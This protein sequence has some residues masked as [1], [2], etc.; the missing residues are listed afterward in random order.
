[1]RTHGFPLAPLQPISGQAVVNWVFLIGD[2]FVLRVNRPNVETDD[3]Y[4]ERVAVPAAR[5]A[6]I[7]TPELL[8]FDDSRAILDSVATIY[9]QSPGKALGRL[10]NRSGSLA[11]IYR[12]LGKQIARLQL[13]VTEV[14]DPNGWL[15]EEEIVDC[16]RELVDAR[17]RGQLDE[18]TYDW[19]A[20]W[21][22]RLEPAFEPS[23]DKVFVHADLHAFNTLVDAETRELVAIIDWGDAGWMDPAT[24]FSTIPIWAVPWML[25]GYEQS[26]GIVDD[27]FIG[28]ILWEA[29]GTLLTWEDH[30]G[31]EPWAPKPTSFWA[32]L[33]RLT[34]MSLDGRWD[35]W[36]PDP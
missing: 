13:H 19:L 27:G 33:V 8:V 15:D 9:E 36:L 17:E 14:E 34:G 1:M 30:P 29:L 5:A 4:T 22:D 28:R 16:R 12:A 26:G 31:D 2:A 11:G 23:R 7:A 6:G 21:I 10:P 24:D 20:R 3:A 25:E 32:N 18:L 35:R